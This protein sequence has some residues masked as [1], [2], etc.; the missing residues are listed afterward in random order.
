MTKGINL[1][2]YNLFSIFE[3]EN[4]AKNKQKN[5]RSCRPELVSGSYQ[6]VVGRVDFSC[7]VR[8]FDAPFLISYLSL[9]NSKMRL[10]KDLGVNIELVNRTGFNPSK[11][12][13]KY[14]SG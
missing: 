5:R 12:K 6:N 3:A 11:I 1:L 2:K 8:R 14:V 4:L 9:K 7:R 10:F 13:L